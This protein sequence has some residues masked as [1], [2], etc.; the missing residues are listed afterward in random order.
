MKF[1][2]GPAKGRFLSLRRAPIF[3]RV[4]IDIDGGVDALDQ[5]GDT[6]SPTETI[7]VY[8]LASEP[9][10][11]IV[12]SRGKGAGC[13]P[14]VTADYCLYDNQPT[15]EEAREGSCWRAWCL[16]QAEEGLW[17]LYPTGTMNRVPLA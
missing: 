15:D 8:R 7:H 11:F 14:G 13:N 6:P 4:V 1:L 2:D 5:P 3:L 17:P 9:S 16:L 12:C 10:H